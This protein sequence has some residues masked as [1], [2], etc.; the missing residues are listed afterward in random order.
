MD[1]KPDCIVSL[2]SQITVERLQLST[3]EYEELLGNFRTLKCGDAL[4]DERIRS[5]VYSKTAGQVCPSLLHSVVAVSLA[6][7][8]GMYSTWNGC[9]PCYLE[10][11]NVRWLSRT[12]DI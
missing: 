7:E 10:G 6:N 5:D 1:W 4:C 12:S 9:D 3:P 8:R 11:G 2:D